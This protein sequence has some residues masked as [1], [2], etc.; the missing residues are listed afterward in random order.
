MSVYGD[1]YDGQS[2]Q[3]YFQEHNSEPLLDPKTQLPISLAHYK[4]FP[5]FKARLTE[6]YRKKEQSFRDEITTLVD[7]T[8]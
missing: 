4:P 1:V 5:E 8:L 6:F 7:R 3:R 2:L